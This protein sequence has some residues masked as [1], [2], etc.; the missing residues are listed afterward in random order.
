MSRIGILAATLVAGTP[1][2]Y[3]ALGELM[4]ER[5]GV[6]NLGVEGMMLCGAVSAFAVATMTGSLWQGVG[7]GM[8]VGAALAFLFGVLAISF[9]ANQVA[10]G[11]ALAIFG[12]G[13]SSFLGKN[14][15]GRQSC[16]SPPR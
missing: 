15:S 10:V 14:M 5:S 9:K 11:L 16:W 2:V 3:A 13:L 8:L 6:L 7:A 1:L 12:A 4:T